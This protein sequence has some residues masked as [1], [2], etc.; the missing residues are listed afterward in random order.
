MR[1][2]IQYCTVQLHSNIFLFGW[3]SFKTTI[4]AVINEVSRTY[5]TWYKYSSVSN[6]KVYYVFASGDLLL[7]ECRIEWNRTESNR[8]CKH[9]VVCTYDSVLAS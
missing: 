5:N 7:E 4:T 1:T 8:I 6:K 9:H 2:I 3:L